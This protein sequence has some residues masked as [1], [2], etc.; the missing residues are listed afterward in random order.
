MSRGITSGKSREKGF[1][2]VKIGIN[3]KPDKYDKIA[4]K[5]ADALRQPNRGL[6]SDEY[7]IA[8]FLRGGP[9]SDVSNTDCRECNN[10]ENLP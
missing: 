9:R 5:I 6:Q 10:W 4:A 1:N 2:T 3:M 7:I 8:A